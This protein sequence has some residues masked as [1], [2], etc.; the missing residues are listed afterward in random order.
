MGIG[1]EPLRMQSGRHRRVRR[2]VGHRRYVSGHH[3][4]QVR[5]WGVAPS[6]SFIEQPHSNGVAGPREA[7]YP[8]KV[9]S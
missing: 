6:Y 4:N 9:A 2:N 5:F 8:R 3:R 1:Y 7:W